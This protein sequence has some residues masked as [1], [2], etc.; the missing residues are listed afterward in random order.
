MHLHGLI[1]S[2]GGRGCGCLRS[3]L[4]NW[5]R[6]RRCL[7]RVLRRPLGRLIHVL[8]PVV[9]DRETSGHA[10]PHS[11]PAEVTTADA[12]SAKLSTSLAKSK[13]Q[14]NEGGYLENE[15]HK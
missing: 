5:H 3:R 2:N 4:G 1:A 6:R 7:A 10:V 12:K 14:N 11:C 9:A 8:V 15:K 13:A